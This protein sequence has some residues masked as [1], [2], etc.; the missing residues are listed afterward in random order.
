M[1]FVDSCCSC[2]KVPDV[3]VYNSR[4][5]LGSRYAFT[6]CRSL[7]P[8]ET[9][10]LKSSIQDLFYAFFLFI[11]GSMKLVGGM[12]HHKYNGMS[13]FQSTMHL[14]REFFLS[15]FISQSLF[16]NLYFYEIHLYRLG[17]FF[18]SRTVLNFI[19]DSLTLVNLFLLI[20]RKIILNLEG[21][22]TRKIFSHIC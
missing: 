4:K 8:G 12:H 15:A 1:H 13:F 10:P 3:Q 14:T 5:V 22:P 17:I 2:L 18:H 19:S 21:N 16:L 6:C 7:L 20:R 11:K 9:L